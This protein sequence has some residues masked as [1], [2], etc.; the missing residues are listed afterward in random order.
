DTPTDTPTITPTPLECPQ[1]QGY[2]K[3]H[4]GRWPV[5]HLTLG[6]QVYNKGE[7]LNILG[8]PDTSDASIALA[9]QLI[10]AKLNIA[11]GVVP[12]QSVLDDIAR[13]DQLLSMFSGKLPY[14]VGN[15]T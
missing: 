10:A 15:N 8:L 12:P 11:A 4:P 14:N 7:L 13:A 1:G 9:I 6:S 3:N 2:W 5:N